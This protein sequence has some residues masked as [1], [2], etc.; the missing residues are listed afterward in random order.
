MFYPSIILLYAVFFISFYVVYATFLKE[1]KVLLYMVVFIYLIVGTVFTY[2]LLGEIR[3]P[4]EGAN[5]LLGFVLLVTV[6]ISFLGILASG[7]IF[8]VKKIHRRMPH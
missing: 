4:S 1:S 2:L 6:F 5:I 8:V 7:I 3:Q